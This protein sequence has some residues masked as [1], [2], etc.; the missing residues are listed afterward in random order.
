LKLLLGLLTSQKHNC[1]QILTL[2]SILGLLFACFSLSAI[3][4]AAAVVVAVA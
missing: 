1:I 4:D 2:L 3:K